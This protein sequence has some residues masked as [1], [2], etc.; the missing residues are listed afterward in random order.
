M[1]KTFENGNAL[2]IIDG[3][4]DRIEISS[5]NAVI[6]WVEE[7]KKTNKPYVISIM[8][9]QSSGKSTLLNF[10]FGAKLKVSAGRCTK[11]LYAMLLRTDFK[12]TKEILI[13]DSEGIFSIEREDLM[14]DRRL[15]T[16][17]MAVSNL[18]LIN[19][20]GEISLEIKKVLEVSIYAL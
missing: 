12:E 2:E 15:V 11:G 19:I 8:G 3:D 5:L 17:C 20:K 18:I 14:F 13:L 6:D 7:I 1:S 10:L 9:P 4:I 16:F